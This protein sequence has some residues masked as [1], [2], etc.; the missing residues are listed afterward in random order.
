MTHTF[1][2]A[3][4][5]PERIVRSAE[6]GEIIGTSRTTCWRLERAGEF[7]ARVQISPGAI[8]YLYSEIQAWIQE[9]ATHR[10]CLPPRVSR[11]VSLPQ[12]Q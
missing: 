10:G 11:P 8:G 12:N 3:D 2:D 1:P 9:R 4:T 7:P 5:G 6:A